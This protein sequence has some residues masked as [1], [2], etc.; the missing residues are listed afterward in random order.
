MESLS[1]LNI[2]WSLIPI[3]ST[4]CK[5]VMAQ[6]VDIIHCIRNAVKRHKISCSSVW[7]KPNCN[8]TFSKFYS[9]RN[10]LVLSVLPYVVFKY[11]IDHR[12]QKNW[13][14]FIKKY[15]YL[16]IHSQKW[17][18][19]DSFHVDSEAPYYE[20]HQNSDNIWCFYH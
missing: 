14:F 5:H 11:H 15:E 20:G 2:Q 12:S 4:T 6:N 13:S 19:Y 9:K 10:I 16:D 18:T 1:S 3:C 7:K 8:M 17:D